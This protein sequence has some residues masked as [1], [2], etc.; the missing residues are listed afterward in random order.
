MFISGNEKPFTLLNHKYY[1]KNKYKKNKKNQ[2]NES[3]NNTLKSR[4][5]M[6]IWF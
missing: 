4:L 5:R 6:A 1:S 3:N 2:N